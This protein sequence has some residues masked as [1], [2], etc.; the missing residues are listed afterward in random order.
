[1]S[2]VVLGALC[3]FQRLLAQIGQDGIQ[4]WVQVCEPIQDRAGDLQRRHFLPT[5][6]LRDVAQR[7]KQQPRLGHPVPFPEYRRRNGLGACPARPGLSL[8]M[9]LATVL[10]GHIRHIHGA[11]ILR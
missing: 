4:T 7:S 6:L 5:N 11:D 3:R 8:S 1:M 2:Y 10:Q 9:T